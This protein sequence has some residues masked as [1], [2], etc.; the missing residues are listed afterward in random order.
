METHFGAWASTSGPRRSST[1]MCSP[2]LFTRTSPP[3]IWRAA[4][5]GNS[6]IWPGEFCGAPA[7]SSFWRVA[8]PATCSI[9]GR[10]AEARSCPAP[11]KRPGS[12]AGSQSPEACR[13]GSGEQRFQLS[14]RVG[15]GYPCE[16]AKVFDQIDEQMRAWIARQP[17]YFT[18]SAPLSG[19]GH[20]NVS[21]KGP[22][23]T[24]RVIGP[25]TVAYLDMVGSGSETIAHLRENGRIVIMLCAFDGPPRIVRIHGRGEVVWPAESRFE[26]LLRRCDFEQPKVAEARRAIVLV[27]VTRIS[28]S[29]GYGVPL[30]RH[31]GSR[32]HA[33]LWAA[34]QLRAKG[35]EALRDYQRTKNATSLDGLPAVE[36]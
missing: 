20:V 7:H 12:K 4:W 8:G 34:K 24:L 9:P 17:L 32:E 14:P 23:G 19:A 33:D 10:M 6:R 25:R 13:A 3:W 5:L 2:M 11:A 28:A 21:P 35:S 15:A 31:E 16:M 18:G 29:C 27:D 1:S 26:A 22:I 30:M 36:V